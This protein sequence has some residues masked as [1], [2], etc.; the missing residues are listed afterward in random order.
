MRAIVGLAAALPALLMLGAEQLLAQAEES[1][2][3][4]FVQYCAL[5]H[6]LDGRGAGPLTDP[7]E[8]MKIAPADLTHIAKRNDGRFPFETVAQMIRDGGGIT[9]HGSTAMPRWGRIF[10]DEQDPNAARA[11]ESLTRYIET[12]QEK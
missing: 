8:A 11:I 1:G 10:S 6:G 7:V 4:L 3:A 2:K 9:A 12:L 5:C